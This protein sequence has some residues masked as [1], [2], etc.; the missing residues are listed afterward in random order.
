VI[1]RLH[2]LLIEMLEQL[3]DSNDAKHER[4]FEDYSAAK[5][6][7]FDLANQYYELT[8]PTEFAFDKMMSMEHEQ[9]IIS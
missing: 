2:K 4:S 9:A 5:S 3:K 8:T 7:L 6:K 1:Q